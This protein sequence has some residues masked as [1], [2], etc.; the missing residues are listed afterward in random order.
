[1]RQPEDYFERDEDGIRL[2][3]HRMWLENIID[4]Y[5]EGLSA[6]QMVDDDHFPT[7]TLDEAQAAIAYYHAHT[8]G[9]EA[10]IE[11][12]QREAEE[13]ER[14]ADKHI[15]AHALRMRALLEERLRGQAADSKQA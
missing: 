12:Q 11:Q 14:E 8:P 2:K 15:S 6:E 3:G 9:V 4:L 10:Y 13:R 7:P 5:K 1:M